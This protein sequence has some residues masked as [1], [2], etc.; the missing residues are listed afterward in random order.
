VKIGNFFHVDPTIL[1]VV[2]LVESHSSKQKK[3]CRI[4]SISSNKKKVTV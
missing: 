2:K 3:H 4:P 1:C